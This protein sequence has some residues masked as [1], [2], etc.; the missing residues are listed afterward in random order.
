LE[1]IWAGICFCVTSRMLKDHPVDCPQSGMSQLVT[2]C[3]GRISAVQ[4]ESAVRCQLRIRFWIGRSS[5]LQQP[6]TSSPRPKYRILRLQQMSWMDAK[7]TFTAPSS[8]GRKR[9]DCA[10]GFTPEWLITSYALGVP[11]RLRASRFG[12]RHSTPKKRKRP[13]NGGRKT[14]YKT[15][16]DPFRR[17]TKRSKA[18]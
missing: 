9:S 12:T 16:S 14:L 11:I 13:P 4:N 15:D 18:S 7:Q 3:S 5:R 1:A 10:V 2:A 6:R 17:R 8:S